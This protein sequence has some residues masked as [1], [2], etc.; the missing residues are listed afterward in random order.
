M[1]INKQKILVRLFQII[2][3]LNDLVMCFSRNYCLLGRKVEEGEVIMINKNVY[4]LLK[5]SFISY[6]NW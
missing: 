4:F 6:L 1:K 3:F 5:Q 2:L